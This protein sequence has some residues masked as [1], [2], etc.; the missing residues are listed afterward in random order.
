[1]APVGA[2]APL[3]PT[4][5]LAAA[6]PTGAPTQAPTPT[7]SAVAKSK[8]ATPAAAGAQKIKIAALGDLPVYVGP[9]YSAND[10]KPLYACT[11]LAFNSYLTAVQMQMQGLDVA[12]GFHLAL[13][14][15]DY[16]DDYAALDIDTIIDRV[17]TGTWDCDISTADVAARTGYGV[18]TAIVDESSGGDGIYARGVD[19]IYDL[20]GKRIA[21][22]AGDSTQYFVNYTLFVA[23]LETADVTLKPFDTLEAAVEAFTKG[24]VDAVSGYDPY[25]TPLTESGGKPLI[26]SD[27]LRVIIDVITTSPVSIKNKPELVQNFHNAWFDAMKLQVDDYDSAAKAISGW[28]GNDWSGISVENAA[29]DFRDGFSTIA[30]ADLAA[31]A[32]V[33]KSP[34]S[35]F[36][37][38][39]AARTVSAKTGPVVTTPI[40]SLLEPRFVVGADI[41][42]R[43]TQ[44]RPLNNT[45]SLAGANSGAD[46]TSFQTVLPCRQ[47][48]FL[49]NTAELD[50]SSKRVLDLCVV[51]ALRQRPGTKLEIIGSAAWPGPAG[52][53]SEAQ[54]KD[55]GLQRAQAVAAYLVQNGIEKAR[56]TTANVLPPVER[57][58]QLNEALQSKDRYVQMTI[59][60]GGW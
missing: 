16:G 52:K 40:K 36:V 47:Y 17:K 13:I 57:R 51:P 23:N 37:A 49:P 21:F 46:L 12:H 53:Y 55:F 30:S 34:D 60:G 24:E 18:I 3:P 59:M 56:L 7:G 32:A 8:P 2:K 28:G 50:E 9:N 26:L 45:F 42:K 20:K 41:A 10:G 58:E 35:L 38:L 44:K 5:T 1:M 54:V 19:S 43:R 39:N 14:P 4:A 27:Q 48:T 29:R 22:V 15:Y 11:V 33:M 25:L 31:N 6:K